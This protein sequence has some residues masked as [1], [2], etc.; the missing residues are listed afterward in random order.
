MESRG[1]AD[2]EGARTQRSKGDL[3]LPLRRGA[4]HSSAWSL[5]PRF[6]QGAR[7]FHVEA[8]IPALETDGPDTF[9]PV[10]ASHTTGGPRPLSFFQFSAP[11]RVTSLEV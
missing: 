5:I 2:S 8:S 9:H 11:I 1:G 6:Q 4:L 3:T 7:R 10:R